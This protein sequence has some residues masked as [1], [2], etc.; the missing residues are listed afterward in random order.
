MTSIYW[1]RAWM[2]PVLMLLNKCRVYL[3]RS[4]GPNIVA[5]NNI[6]LTINIIGKT[7]VADIAYY[8]LK[9]LLCLH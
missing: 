4:F 5:Y 6:W 1:L 2:L 7:I 9:R 8:I 3:V